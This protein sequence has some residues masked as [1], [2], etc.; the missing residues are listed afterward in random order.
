[1]VKFVGR[2]DEVSDF[3]KAL[4]REGFSANSINAY[5]TDVRLFLRYLK[6]KGFD[7]KHTKREH[8]LTYLW[9]RLQAKKKRISRASARRTISSL[10][11]FFAFL[12]DEGILK[13]S[14]MIAIKLPRV[15]REAPTVLNL[16]EVESILN[17]TN[18]E[19]CLSARNLA[20]LELLY[21]AG[22]RVGELVSLQVDSVDIENGSLVVIGKGGKQRIAV[23]GRSA[24][25]ALK[26]YLLFRHGL[27]K[28]GS[29]QEK[30]L[31]LTKN[32][33]RIS[34]YDVYSIVRKLGVRAGIDKKVTPHTLRHSFATHLLEGGADL[35]SIQV[36]LGHKM[37]ATTNIY[38]HLSLEHLM[39]TYEN[40]HPRAKR[41]RK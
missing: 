21:S 8:I 37:L 26:N 14:P 10:A 34:R 3:A 38:T 40:A 9:E 20:I 22:L 31:F 25:K 17:A 39:N 15:K 2:M 19:E 41:T 32:G 5:S 30:A 11:R 1:M 4:A 6:E 7:L 29:S 33:K 12:L 24:K 23:F 27:I 36:L 13:E 18:K 35:R 16:G 28:P